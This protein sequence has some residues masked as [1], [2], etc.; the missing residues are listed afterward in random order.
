MMFM[1]IILDIVGGHQR[2]DDV[3]T[4]ELFIRWLQ[5]STFMPSI[6]FSIA[7]WDFD[8]S[9]VEIALKFTQLHETYAELILERF[10]L[11]VEKG[12]PGLNATQRNDDGFKLISI[13]FKLTLRFG[14]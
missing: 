4:K 3:L 5:A 8:Q 2:S 10:Q 12:E 1:T 6:Q 11:A 14:G 7:P 9:T 13:S